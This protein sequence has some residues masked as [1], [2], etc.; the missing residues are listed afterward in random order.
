VKKQEKYTPMAEARQLKTGRWRL[1]KT[2]DLFPARDRETGAI[3]TFNSLTEARQWWLQHNPGEA[4]PHEAIKC[5]KGGAYFG[6][7]STPTLS[8]GLHYHLSHSP[9]FHRPSRRR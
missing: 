7:D 9:E 5:S 6:R 2:P 4:P 8:G 1:Y 3:L